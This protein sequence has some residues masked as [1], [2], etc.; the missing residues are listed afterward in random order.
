[1]KLFYSSGLPIYEGDEIFCFHIG[2]AWR[3]AQIFHIYDFSVEDRLTG[4][5]DRIPWA[6]LAGD[7]RTKTAFWIYGGDETSLQFEL[8]LYVR[9]IVPQVIQDLIPSITKCVH[10]YDDLTK[11]FETYFSGIA[12]ADG[13]VENIRFGNTLFSKRFEQ[14][15]TYRGAMYASGIEVKLGDIILCPLQPYDP[16]DE[17]AA[18]ERTLFGIV[19]EYG[20]DGNN[21]ELRLTI[22]LDQA[23]KYYVER[24][25]EDF[26]GMFLQHEDGIFYRRATGPRLTDAELETIQTFDRELIREYYRTEPPSVG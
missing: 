19:S 9:G 20:F 22:M 10:N 14:M 8:V 23:S 12:L 7:I 17:N 2:R 11:N 5:D 13:F 3:Y 21:R 26:E 18:C 15:K 25:D 4:I 24:E 6:I 1:M 16:N